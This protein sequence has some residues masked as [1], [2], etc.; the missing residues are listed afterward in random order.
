[1]AID[2]SHIQNQLRL[3][4]LPQTSSCTPLAETLK[5]FELDEMIEYIMCSKSWEE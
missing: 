5:E 2:I 4:L 3:G 1:M